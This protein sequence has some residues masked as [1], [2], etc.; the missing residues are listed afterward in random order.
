MDQPLGWTTRYVGASVN[1][2]RSVESTQAEARRLIAE[3]R[4]EGA[5]VVA[6]SQT[7]GRGRFAR[8]WQSPPGNLYVSVILRP[9]VPLTEW[10][11]IMMLASLALVETLDDIGIAEAAIKWP[12]DILVGGRKVAGLL[13]EIE[14]M[15]LILGIGV[16]V[17]A[18]V[19]S[20]LPS[21]TSLRV[22]IGHEVELEALLQA[23]VA[24]L[25]NYY[26]QLLSGRRFTTD[27]AARMDTLG[28]QVQVLAGNAVVAG[29]V[30]SVDPDGALRVR[31]SDGT[32]AIFHG[33]EVTLAS[34]G[35]KS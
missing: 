8:V 32:I 7:A 5:L 3:G 25:D 11:Q 21:A 29:I 2:Y 20:D 34:Q 6:V 1:R 33:G 27:W 17:N 23:L 4:G 9:P 10:P 14:R 31:Q 24:R 15:H 18:P 35:G 22:A 30:D 12:N 13:S 19:P 26:G 16:N 28:R